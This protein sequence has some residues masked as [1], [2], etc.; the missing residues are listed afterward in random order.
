MSCLI[1]I[2]NSSR[3]GMVTMLITF[4]G[5]VL[6]WSAYALDVPTQKG[7]V[8]DFA[9]ILP[10][11]YAADLD[12]RL[13]RFDQKTDHKVLILTLTSLQGDDIKRFSRKLFVDWQLDDRSKVLVL[14]IVKN[15]PKVQLESSA[16]LEHVRDDPA[17]TRRVQD[18]VVSYLGGY[19][20][21]VGV[22]YALEALVK[23]MNTGQ[24]LG[25]PA[26]QTAFWNVGGQALTIIS[27]VLPL[28]LTFPLG[29]FLGV[30]SPIG[31]LPL[32]VR[33]VVSGGLGGI[34]AL[35]VGAII[36]A[37]DQ[38]SSG[39]WMFIGV[40]GFLFGA[41]GSIREFWSSGRITEK[42]EDKSLKTPYI[43]GI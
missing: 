35:G 40:F 18:S 19:K 5:L 9:N 6:G 15:E 31:R 38:L 24:S 7:Y 37:F 4:S 17:T 26:K 30:S 34:V 41:L 14:T 2:N 10:R 36:S 22:E 1:Q 23:R 39:V 11:D 20:P 8:N 16:V 28:I 3:W 32:Y 27:I 25:L 12:E 42:K 21:E 29:F 33:S 13:R 43:G